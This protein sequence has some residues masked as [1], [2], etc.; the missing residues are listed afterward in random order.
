MKILKFFGFAVLGIFVLVAGLLTYVKVALPDVGEAPELKV[1]GTQELIARGAYLANSVSVCMDCHSTREWTKFSGPTKPGTFGAGGEVF[2]Q[3]FGFPGSYYSRNI[4][5]FGVGE[6]TD[7][8][9]YRAITAGV[10]R[11]GRA[12]FPIMP[13]MYYGKMADSDIHAIIA[14][15]R[16]LEPQES[17]V[18]DSKSD[19]PM[20]FILNTLPTKGEPQPIPHK[21][22]QVL[23]GKYMAN[24]AGCIEC[25]TKQDKGQKLPGMDF[26][27]G[28]EF[29]IPPY[30]IVRSPNITPHATGIGAW[31]EEAFVNRFKFYADSS[32]VPATLEAGQF[33]TVMPWTM[34]ATMEEEDLKAIYAYLRTVAPVENQVVRFSSL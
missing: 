2:N 1:E 30:G 9:L 10:S 16:T 3:D 25:H 7:G 11:D 19:F 5:P 26:A 21:S 17:V 6:W 13:Y 14:Y 29:R 34:Y 28:F 24:A 22:E 12:L 33:Q 31:T 18:P 8:E 20:N 32:Y 27:G 15:I 23:Y 4:T